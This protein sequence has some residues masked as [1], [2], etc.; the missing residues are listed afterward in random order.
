MLVDVTRASG[1][2]FPG[3]QA[4]TM[5]SAQHE[6]PGLAANYKVISTKKTR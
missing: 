1:R 3:Q 2:G 5:G 4:L 6:R